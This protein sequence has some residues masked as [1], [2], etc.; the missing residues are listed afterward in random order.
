MSL[1]FYAQGRHLSTIYVV[2]GP[3]RQQVNG[4]LPMWYNSLH[5]EV[6]TVAA[7]GGGLAGVIVNVNGSGIDVQAPTASNG[8]VM[9]L[10]PPPTLPE[11]ATNGLL[12]ITATY[13]PPP[14]L[15]SS[16]ADETASV[17]EVILS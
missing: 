5:F 2:Q 6:T 9:F 11:H 1:Y 13:S 12:T 10:L 15:G 17:S 8:T 3:G 16:S 14:T 7:A 4:W